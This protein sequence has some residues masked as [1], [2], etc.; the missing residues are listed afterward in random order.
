MYIAEGIAVFEGVV[1]EVG[2]VGDAAGQLL[3]VAQ[4]GLDDGFG[5]ERGPFDAV[6]LGESREEGR[7]GLAGVG[8][9]RASMY[10]AFPRRGAE[11]LVEFMNDFARKNG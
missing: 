1:N 9:M 3:A 5:V 8:G 6:G 2:C 10:N 4:R 11:I 7:E